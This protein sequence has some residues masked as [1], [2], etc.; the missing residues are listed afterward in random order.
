MLWGEKKEE[1]EVVFS[2]HGYKKKTR[3]AAK[4]LK[5]RAVKRDHLEIFFTKQGQII[6]HYIHGKKKVLSSAQ[7]LYN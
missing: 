5:T 1:G 3:T 4:L 7:M 2:N 6:L